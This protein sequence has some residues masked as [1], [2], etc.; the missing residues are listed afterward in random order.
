MTEIWLVIG[1]A[2]QDYGMHDQPVEWIVAA[3]NTEEQALLHQE[4]AGIAVDGTTREDITHAD[5]RK[6]QEFGNLYDPHM[7]VGDRGTI[8]LIR[9]A[10]MYYHLDEFLEHEG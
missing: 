9:K 3:Y 2:M 6:V 7:L 10:R 8:Y 4:K 1:Q 5:R